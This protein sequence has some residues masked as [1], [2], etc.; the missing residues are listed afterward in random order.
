MKK[1]LFL[2]VL[3]FV[4]CP[5]TI[6]TSTCN[7]VCQNMTKLNCPAAKPTAK[8]ATCV[9]VCNNL[10]QSGITKWDLNCRASALTCEAIDLCEL[11]K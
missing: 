8:G 11:G 1:L 6:Q 7:D 9:Q 10:Q 5:P 3:I 2:C 4:G